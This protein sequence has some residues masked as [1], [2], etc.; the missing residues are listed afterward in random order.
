MKHNT[1]D[2]WQ[3]AFI[4]K[5][6]VRPFFEISKDKNGWKLVSVDGKETVSEER[7]LV[8]TIKYCTSAQH[9]LTEGV[10]QSNIQVPQFFY[11]GSEMAMRSAFL[12]KI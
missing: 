7:S 3:A 8:D 1:D 5:D 12:T 11:R 4:G 6:V 10:V 2:F 9:D